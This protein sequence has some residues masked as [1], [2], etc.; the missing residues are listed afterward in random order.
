MA[1]SVPD[2]YFRRVHNTRWF[3]S[4]LQV[5]SLL[6][7]EKQLSLDI[8]EGEKLVEVAD[9][10]AAERQRDVALLQRSF[11][12]IIDCAQDVD[13]KRGL[14][15]L[16]LQ[17]KSQAIADVLAKSTNRPAEW[18]GPWPQQWPEPPVEGWEVWARSSSLRWRAEWDHVVRLAWQAAET[19]ITGGFDV[20]EYG[21]RLTAE[22]T[23][24][25]DDL[26]AV[27]VRS[28]MPSERKYEEKV[29]ISYDRI[30]FPHLYRKLSEEQRE[31]F[32]REDVYNSDL[33]KNRLVFLVNLSPNPLQALEWIQSP[34][35][36]TIYSLLHRYK[37]GG[38]QTLRLKDQD[39]GPEHVK[40]AAC[41]RGFLVRHTPEFAR[42]KEENEWVYLDA[43]LRPH[44]YTRYS[45]PPPSR[46]KS[47]ASSRS[48]RSKVP[49][50]PP[51]DWSWLGLIGVELPPSEIA[52]KWLSWTS[53]RWKAPV[54]V[55]V[56]SIWTSPQWA[57]AA[58]SMHE[59]E[60]DSGMKME[61]IPEN[62]PWATA[63]PQVEEESSSD[64]TLTSTEE[65]SEG[66]DQFTR[67]GSSQGRT[68]TPMTGGDALS[69]YEE[70]EMVG[71]VRS[72]AI[73]T[74]RR[75][76]HL[77]YLRKKKERAQNARN[78]D[79]MSLLSSRSA[80]STASRGL[81]VPQLIGGL[82][83]SAPQADAAYTQE[84]LQSLLDTPWT[85]VE[86]EEDKMTKLLLLTYGSDGGEGMKALAAA[87][88]LDI[89][90]GLSDVSAAF[91]SLHSMLSSEGLNGM[92]RKCAK[93][94]TSEMFERSNKDD[95]FVADVWSVGH[96][97][98][99]THGLRYFREPPRTMQSSLN[100]L[101]MASILSSSVDWGHQGANLITKAH[102]QLEGPGE[103]ERY[104]E[105]PALIDGMLPVLQF[106]SVPPSLSV[107]QCLAM[108]VRVCS[109]IIVQM[110]KKHLCLPRTVSLHN[111][112]HLSFDK[113]KPKWDAL[114]SMA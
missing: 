10:L 65:E 52:A 63:K 83:F 46:A 28:R 100:E 77:L 22:G 95:S 87:S 108:I 61:A 93:T 4:A 76:R 11:R 27:Y 105:D 103:V 113:R 73:G 15:G 86:K 111:P 91:A 54:G 14:D 107:S 80:K 26:Y 45:T 70:E 92:L 18:Q 2:P 5:S 19:L 53:S 7:R 88:R 71:D 74:K 38:G 102:D 9:A 96:G 31:A 109:T 57:S 44:L 34:E 41:A 112:L 101:E 98:G 106:Y 50:I 64:V 66:D 114:C 104:D 89:V 51:D 25:P 59:S 55:T 62:D 82:S 35:D 48:R 69:A 3:G 110:K 20:S 58:S 99:L 37:S 6:R 42:T 12:E 8:E 68:R 21:G 39:S 23:L 43:K 30:L 84:K 56:T 85:K 81:G 17:R 29:W 90:E 36:F 33:P 94:I 16:S 97:V 79:S 47:R 67:P 78:Q 72:T 13:A 60:H 24:H 49:E 75:F 1:T 40:V 32:I